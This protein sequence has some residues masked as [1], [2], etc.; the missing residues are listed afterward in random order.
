MELFNSALAAKFSGL[1]FFLKRSRN[2]FEMVADEIGDRSLRTALNGLSDDSSYY[3]GELKNYLKTHGFLNIHTEASEDGDI[4][5]EY[6]VTDS[7][8]QGD[9]LNNICTH[10]ERKLISAYSELLNESLPCPTLKEIMLYQLNALKN[11]FMKVKTL[12]SARF[13]L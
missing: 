12:N 6:P 5:A 11:T 7:A 2:E 8:A 1:L 9:E 4:S 3:A 13:A 10:N